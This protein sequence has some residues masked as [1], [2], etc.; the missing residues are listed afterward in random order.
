[1][2]CLRVLLALFVVQDHSSA[3]PLL[4][5]G[6]FFDGFMAVR[7]FFMVSGFYMAL[8]L[9]S[10]YASGGARLF[11][12]NRFLRLWPAYAFSVVV[13]LLLGA[14]F[15]QLRTGATAVAW[16]DV[17]GALTQWHVGPLLLVGVSTLGMLG[18]ELFWFL[19][20]DPDDG[21]IAF[22][23]WHVD[24]AHNGSM[25]LLNR[26][27]WS[28]SVELL[29]Y[30]LAPFVLRRITL[31]KCLVLIVPGL[32]FHVAVHVLHLDAQL[33]G[34]FVLPAALPF[35]GLGALAFW[36]CR[37]VQREASWRRA[38]LPA[39]AVYGALLLFFVLFLPGRIYFMC[40][41]FAVLLP[42]LFLLFRTSRIDRAI[43]EFSYPLYI[44]H[45]P[46]VVYF[47][48]RRVL[49]PHWGGVQVVLLTLL[50]AAP[51]YLLVDRPIGRWRRRRLM[52]P[53]QSH[54]DGS[55]QAAA[56]P[57]PG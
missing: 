36:V 31:P 48:E 26:P 33:W 16:P 37:R 29:F 13:S 30:L 38:L 11:Y 55:A 12:G 4:W 32:L 23:P 10:T 57:E 3:L 45:F 42:F 54:A 52:P 49:S 56:A 51:V 17:F 7:C 6:W 5:R 40:L 44:L 34:Y 53:G 25:F 18:Q 46:I 39:G 27:A 28:V 9:N 41:G 19:R 22:A 14:W 1:M 43:G 8:I 47:F 21:A 20:L 50:L 15:G 35:F 24:A 2:G